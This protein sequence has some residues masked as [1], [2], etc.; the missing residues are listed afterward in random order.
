MMSGRVRSR[1]QI[2]SAAA[3]AKFLF[4]SNTM[5]KH[6]KGGYILGNLS[7]S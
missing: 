2:I 7:L 6:Y 1:T 4:V 5:K 3:L